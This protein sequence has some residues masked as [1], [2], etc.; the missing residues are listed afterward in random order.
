MSGFVA[1]MRNHGAMYCTGCVVTTA[2]RVTLLFALRFC[3]AKNVSENAAI[4]N[5]VG[6]AKVVMPSRRA[7]QFCAHGTTQRCARALG[8]AVAATEMLS[9][10]EPRSHVQRPQA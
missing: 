4:S 5:I 10:L 2:S 8:V 3:S 7:G 9:L 6:M 1:S